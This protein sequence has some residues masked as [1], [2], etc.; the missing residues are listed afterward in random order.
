M[1]YLVTSD[2]QE[3]L[4]KWVSDRG[5]VV[6]QKGFFLQMQGSL[7]KE[8]Q[9][10]LPGEDIKFL[11][12]LELRELINNC[13]SLAS[14]NYPSII[15]LDGG[16]YVTNPDFRLDTSR[17][18]NEKRELIGLGSRTTE[19]IDTQIQKILAQV[20]DTPI[21][22][23]DEG[24]YTGAGI[25]E[26]IT[27]L[28]NNCIRVQSVVWGMATLEAYDCVKEQFP[29]IQLTPGLL[30][31][32]ITD[33]VCER[34]FYPGVPLSGRL[35]GNEDGLP[36]LPETGAPYVLPFGD[37]ENWASIPKS[38]I[39]NFSTFCLK[40]TISLWREVEKLSNKT[41]RCCD[42]ARRPIGAP[43]NDSSFV[44]YLASLP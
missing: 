5:F 39:D 8:L 6:P 28:Q 27:M 44:E 1:Q 15:S 22:L 18:I 7:K 2:V 29:E 31:A 32:S 16:V 21:V 23:V 26:V 20:Q 19:S 38:R 37:P 35:V 24:A 9:R 30:F 4:T 17:I 41:V 13:L 10:C 33:W 43:N 3:L 11:S 40:E 42:L 25:A 36:L 12:Y 14:L 34:D